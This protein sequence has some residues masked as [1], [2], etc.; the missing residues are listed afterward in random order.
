MQRGP[1]SLRR[2]RGKSRLALSSLSF[3]AHEVKKRKSLLWHVSWRGCAKGA[4]IS[5]QSVRSTTTAPAGMA[6]DVTTRAA[7][8]DAAVGGL[9]AVAAAASKGAVVA[10]GK[11]QVAALKARMV[12]GDVASPGT[13]AAGVLGGKGESDSVLKGV[14]LLDVGNLWDDAWDAEAPGSSSSRRIRSC[15]FC[16]ELTELAN[17]DPRG[18]LKTAGGGVGIASSLEVF[19]RLLAGCSVLGLPRF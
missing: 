14:A 19:L 3:D 1:T 5:S 4:S 12:A 10:A 8:R 17:E 11:L 15:W 13:R 16:E 2:R 6:L 7:G 9:V 18:S